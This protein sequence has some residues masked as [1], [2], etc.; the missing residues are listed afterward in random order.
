MSCCLLLLGIVLGI[1]DHYKK[2]RS[3]SLEGNMGQDLHKSVCRL[4]GVEANCQLTQFDVCAKYINH[5]CHLRIL[6]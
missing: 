5:L 2:A 4:R 6:A 1:V 3:Y